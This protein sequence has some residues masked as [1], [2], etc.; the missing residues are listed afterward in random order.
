MFVCVIGNKYIDR[1]FSLDLVNTIN[2]VD[3]VIYDEICHLFFNNWSTNLIGTTPLC[4]GSILSVDLT[5][6]IVAFCLQFLVYV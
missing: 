6:P 4:H 1:C 5:V 3:V 2:D